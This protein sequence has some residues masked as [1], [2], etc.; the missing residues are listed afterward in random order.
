MTI[1]ADIVQV[2]ALGLVEVELDGRELPLATDGVFHFEIDLRSVES[3]AAAVNVVVQSRAVERIFQ[4]CLGSFP[5]RRV[6]Y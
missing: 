5:L 4:R 3:P 1:F 2:K 6:T